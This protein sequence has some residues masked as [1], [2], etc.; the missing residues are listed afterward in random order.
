MKNKIIAVIAIATLPLMAMSQSTN[1]DTFTQIYS[2]I[3]S[4]GVLS[5]TNYSID[6]YAT[7][8]PHAPK[9]DKFGGGA[10]ITYNMNNYM[11]LAIGGDYLGQFSLVSGNVTLR[12]PMNLNNYISASWATNFIVTPF[13]L[14]GIGKPTGGSSGGAAIIADAGLATEFGHLWGGRFNAGVSY[15]SWSGAGNY[16]GIRY[17]GFFGWSH[18]F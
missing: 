5:S 13:V 11:G 7:Y 6:P 14:A 15:G 1:T 9:G 3:E 8:A 18:G 10:L 12:L 2:A 16:S 4:S 17:H